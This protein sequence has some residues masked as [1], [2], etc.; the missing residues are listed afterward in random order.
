MEAKETAASE[1]PVLKLLDGW[2]NNPGNVREL[3]LK[4]KEIISKKPEVV[5]DFKARPGVSYSLRG[6][7]EKPSEKE[8]R[9]F[10][11]VDV[12]DDDPDNRW[13]SVCF[14]E[15]W[16]TDPKGEGNVVPEGLFGMDGYCFD[17]F[18][19][20]ESGLSYVAQRVDE[21]YA[22]ASLKD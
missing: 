13:L 22:H 1:D 12:I 15:E 21:A 3:F 11:V 5:L 18:E 4:L 17:M 14:Y 16:V 10:V 6:S 9:F 7:V 19:Y 20:N 2:S 8:K